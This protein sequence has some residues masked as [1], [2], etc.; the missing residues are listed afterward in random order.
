LGLAE[1]KDQK[2][3]NNYVIYLVPAL[4]LLGLLVW[5]Q[6]RPGLQSRMRAT[7]TLQELAGHIAEEHGILKEEW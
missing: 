4:G 6:V 7:R 5:D 2:S 3:I 1:T